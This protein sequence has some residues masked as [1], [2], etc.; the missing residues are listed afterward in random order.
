MPVNSLDHEMKHWRD[1]PNADR[2]EGDCVPLSQ[3]QVYQLHGQNSLPFFLR[4]LA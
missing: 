3:Q 2:P 1:C 4:A